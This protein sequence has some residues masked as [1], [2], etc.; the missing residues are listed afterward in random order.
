MTERRFQRIVVLGCGLVGSSWVALFLGHGYSVTAWDPDRGALDTLPTRVSRSLRQLHQIGI[1]GRGRLVVESDFRGAVRGAEFV[2]ENAP[3]RL[4]LKRRLY[5][6]LEAVVDRTTLISASTSSFVWSDLA[7]G[8]KY[9][10]RLF[11]AHPFNPPHLI[12][13]VELYGR[14]SSVT[15][16][17]TAFYRSLGKTVVVLKKEATGHIANRLASALWR[18]AVHI[19]AEGIA[20]VKDVDDALVDGPGLRWAVM[21]ANLTYHLGGGV[22]G[23]KT[24]LDHLGSSQERRWKDL[25]APRLTPQ[26][27]RRIAQGVLAEAN[28]RSVEQLEHQRDRALIGVLLARQRRPRL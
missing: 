25:G 16:L 17:A 9:G 13:L 19:V 27:R 21:G 12:P 11:T 8:L 23:I 7:E 15:R 1:S 10:E 5:R 3:E 14:S 20:D 18:E 22:G 2:Q 4:E 24:Y 6:D 28:G 26:L